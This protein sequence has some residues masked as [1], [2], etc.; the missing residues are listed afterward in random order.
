MKI[1]IYSSQTF[2]SLEDMKTALHLKELYDKELNGVSDD[3]QE[4]G[5]LVQDR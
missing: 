3:G 1:I 4:K 2:L 5:L